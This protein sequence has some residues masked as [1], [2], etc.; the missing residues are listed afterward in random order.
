M[1][2][3]SFLLRIVLCAAMAFNGPGS[4]LAAMHAVS[5]A[6]ASALAAQPPHAASHARPPCHGHEEQPQAEAVTADQHAQVQA[7]H[8]RHHDHDAP[9][10]DCCRSGHCQCACMQHCPAVVAMPRLPL[11][12]LAP[13]ILPGLPAIAHLAPALPRLIRP[14]IR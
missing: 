14:P 13:G 7:S 9:A 1:P 5:L 12:G 10:P 6:P 3:R 4:A 8:A 2:S 11:P